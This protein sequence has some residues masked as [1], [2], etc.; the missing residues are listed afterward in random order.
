[1][2]RLTPSDSMFLYGES[3][4]V[5]MHV[6]GLL[7]FTQ[8]ADAPPDQMRGLMDEIRAGAPVYRPWNQR[9]RT[10]DLL[11]NPLQAWQ[12]VEVDLEYHVRRTAL[13]SPGDERELGIVVSRLH[14]HHIDFH[15][16]PWEVHLIE[17]LEG[18]RFALYVK[19]HHSLV[20]GFTAM[21]IL[22]NALSTDPAE[23][24]RPL[25]FSIP[26]PVRKPRDEAEGVAV[27]GPQLMAI[28]REQYGASKTA[29]RALRDVFTG[30]HAGLVTPRQAPKCVL[31][32][33][34]S[35]SRRFA[36]QSLETARMRAV[37]K[38]S[39]GTLNDVILAVSAA[40]LRRYLFEQDALPDDP[41]VA[42][43]PVAVRAKDE[44]GG[45][46]AVGAI[47]VSLATDI[48]DVQE[49]IADIIQSTREAKQQLSGMSK[50]AI[51]QYSAMLLAPS[52]AQMIP[53]TAGH[54]KPTFNVVISNV[55]GP[56]SP[57]YF[58]GARLDAAYPM[59][60]P[61]HGQALNITVNSYAGNMCFGFTGCRDTVP[62]LQRLA[63]YCGEA[64][65][66]LEQAFGL[67]IG[68][69]F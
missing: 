25:F 69:G 29:L 43:V 63:V 50:A 62:H 3:R 28:V 36:T 19:V 21:K 40:S 57:L 18:R 35:R 37:A 22:N 46:N 33:R 15:R 53:T 30:H 7:T 55:P 4:E 23:R 31:N 38:A 24:D 52:L 60:I 44:D 2:K 13:P 12:E 42:M 49:R 1:M 54:V 39:G 47:L 56:D 6:G 5:M 64:L 20:D 67:A 41:L 45:G 34:I 10:P 16:P 66:E 32:A 9:L 68:T 17:G 14:G 26:P 48:D 59:S 8:P 51:L 27:H 58:R 11:W 61:V 65:V